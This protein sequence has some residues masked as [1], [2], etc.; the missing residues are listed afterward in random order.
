MV[1]QLYTKQ[2][3]KHF[4]G[5]IGFCL[6]HC[7]VKCMLVNFQVKNKSATDENLQRDRFRAETF[8]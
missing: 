2:K 5:Y 8:V 3:K 6:F 7:Y 1:L 4:I